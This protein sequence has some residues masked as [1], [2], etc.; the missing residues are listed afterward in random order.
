MYK[1]IHDVTIINLKKNYT[2][3]HYF[4][5]GFIQIKLGKECR[6][7]IYTDSLPA[8]TNE[9][10]IHN[11]RY[12]FTST[13][14]HGELRQELFSIIQGDSHLLQDESCQEGYVPNT[15]NS[16]L[17]SI[18]KTGEQVFIQGNS[19]SIDHN[20]FHRVHTRN[21]VTFLTRS[22]YKKELAQVVHRRDAQKVCPFS[23]K[24]KEEEL[25]SIVEMILQQIV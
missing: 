23:K 24:V 18:Q 7:H 8:I 16:R 6:L 20:T 14:L 17:C 19:Y 4:G 5:L 10:D 15:V 2:L 22:D 12:N 11:H 9:E 21:A 13:I 1:T 3:I 25:W